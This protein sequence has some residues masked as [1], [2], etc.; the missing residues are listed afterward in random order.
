MME[1]VLRRA[2][3]LACMAVIAPV[4]LTVNII[5]AAVKFVR[6]FADTIRESW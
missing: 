3:L 4:W 6:D 1:N 5:A 2:W